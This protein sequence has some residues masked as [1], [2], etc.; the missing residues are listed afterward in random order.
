MD[1]AVLGLASSLS[2]N[3]ANPAS[4]A[5]RTT[6]TVWRCEKRICHSSLLGAYAQGPGKHVLLGSLNDL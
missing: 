1:V 4:V 2:G 6:A 5:D 3:V